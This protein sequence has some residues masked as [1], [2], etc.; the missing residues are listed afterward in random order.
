MIVKRSRKTGFWGVLL[1]QALVLALALPAPGAASTKARPGPAADPWSPLVERLAADG[2]DK[3]ELAELFG[4]DRV[5][6][7]PDPMRLKMR[8][9]YKTMFG[10]GP[11]LAAQKGLQRLGYKVGSLDGR[12]GSQTRRAIQAFQKKNSL[13]Q[14]GLPDGPLRR[15]IEAELAQR[16][17]QPPPQATESS[18]VYSSA[19]TKAQLIKTSLYLSKHRPLLKQVRHKYGVPEEIAVGILTVETKVGTYLGQ[20]RALTT[21]A[22]MALCSDFKKVSAFFQESELGPVRTKW[23]K[24]RSGEK[25]HWAYQELKALLKYAR[26]NRPTP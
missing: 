1:L 4:R 6:Y 16:F 14:T 18:R 22:S 2:L 15:M 13:P 19:L 5:R 21:L 3:K 17:K 24:K 12:Y 11:V 25:A 9:L 20:K 7:D 23:L 10:R 8:S 26:V